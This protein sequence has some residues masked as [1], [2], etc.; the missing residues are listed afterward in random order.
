MIKCNMNS[1]PVPGSC[2][3]CQLT[4]PG[5]AVSSLFPG[6]GQSNPSEALSMESSGLLF[7]K[8]STSLKGTGWGFS[9]FLPAWEE[10]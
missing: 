9:D 8:T 4:L 7:Q 1:D 5:G 2:N 10:E 6:T 3:G